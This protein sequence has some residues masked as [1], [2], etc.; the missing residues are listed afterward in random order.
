[1]TSFGAR[2]ILI[3]VIG[4]VASIKLILCRGVEIIL[5]ALDLLRKTIMKNCASIRS[6]LG[7]LRKC[8]L[9]NHFNC[10][11]DNPLVNDHD[12]EGERTQW[13]K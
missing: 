4:S 12:D 5:E 6:E 1:M 10:T 9:L 7:K 3:G 8:H 2:N 11:E 13:I